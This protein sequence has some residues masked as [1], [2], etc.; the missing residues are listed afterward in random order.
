MKKLI[1][2]ALCGAS[3]SGLVAANEAQST[4]S[5]WTASSLREALA[6]RPVG[7]ATRGAELNSAHMCAS[8]HGYKG[9]PPTPRWP[10]T[11]GQLESYTYKMLLDYKDQ[12]RLEDDRANVM[13]AVAEMLSKQDMSD[14][15]AYYASLEAPVLADKPVPALVR[16]GDPERLITPCA[17]CHG[18]N[19][20]GGIK[21]TPAIAGQSAEVLK[22]ALEF[23]Q[24]GE[25][26]SDLYSVMRQAALRLTADE[27]DALANY[28]SGHN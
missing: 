13:T 24:S 27:I 10:A 7:D 16:E 3:L 9:V 18:L 25:R 17:S 2:V 6:E 1:L 26:A 20:Q 12:A 14:L 5:Q 4:A 28:Y 22:R 8:C 11:A 19:G 21:G 23:Y 15:A